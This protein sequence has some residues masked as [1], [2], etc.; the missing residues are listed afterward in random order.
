MWHV[1]GEIWHVTLDMAVDKWHVTW[2]LTYDMWHSS[3][4]MTYDMAG[5]LILDS[6]KKVNNYITLVYTSTVIEELLTWTS[7][8]LGQTPALDLVIHSLAMGGHS[9]HF[10]ANVKSPSNDTSSSSATNDYILAA[11]FFRFCT[12]IKFVGV[13]ASPIMPCFKENFVRIQIR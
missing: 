11:T 13:T 5:S 4:H 12:K 6:C 7:R 2:Q 3:W 8:E 1:I 9:L 10:S